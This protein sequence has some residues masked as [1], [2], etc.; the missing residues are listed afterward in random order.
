MPMPQINSNGG[1]KARSLPLDRSVGPKKEAQR[2]KKEDRE[3]GFQKVRVAVV[4]MPE[5]SWIPCCT[6]R[7]PTT[8]TD[9]HLWAFLPSALWVVSIFRTF[10]LVPGRRGKSGARRASSLEF[11]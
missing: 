2:R 6:S 9:L 8:V 3:L 1:A 4:Y 11:R 5:G 7:G 10:S